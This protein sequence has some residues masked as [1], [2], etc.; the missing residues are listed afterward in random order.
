MKDKELISGIDFKKLK[1]EDIKKLYL[2]YK[3]IINYLVFG[4]I[5]HDSKFW[6]IF[7]ICKVI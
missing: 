7:Y 3:E 2:Q 1:K 4:R 5:S 6:L